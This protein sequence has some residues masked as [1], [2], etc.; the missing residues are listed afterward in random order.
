MIPL[1]DDIP[2]SRFPA[3]T[4]GLIIVNGLVFL[5]EL[6]LGHHLE[7]FLLN[8]GVIP[9]RYTRPEVAQFFSLP[10]QLFAFLSSMFL[11]GGWIHFLGNMW[12]L[13]IFGDN[14][15]DRL[16][17]ARFVGLYLASGLAAAL[18]HILTNPGSLVP[19]IGASGAIAGVMGAY[20]RFYPHA[21]VETLI[22]P[23]FLGP[24]FVLPAVL[25][26]G[27]WFFLQFFNGAL[28]LGARGQGF[29]GVAWWAHV[30]GFLF[31]FGVCLLAP[32]QHR[33]VPPRIIDI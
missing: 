19:T 27:W 22:P 24:T 29:A 6:A 8:F 16:G 32:R 12:T 20:F 15:E 1:R 7:D 4:L 28:S 26:L 25:F 2:A 31:G 18:L 3:V 9:A 13:W 21:R 33:R 10:E 17:R 30:G 11:H 23:F 5:Y 14:V